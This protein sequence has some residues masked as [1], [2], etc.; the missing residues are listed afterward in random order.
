[1]CLS[2][3]RRYYLVTLNGALPVETGDVRQAFAAAAAAPHGGHVIVK[4]RTV[5]C[6]SRKEIWMGRQTLNLSLFALL[7]SAAVAL[8][9]ELIDW[10]GDVTVADA[11]TLFTSVTK[12]WV[13]WCHSS[14]FCRETA[15]CYVTQDSRFSLF[16]PNLSVFQPRCAKHGG[17][18]IVQAD[19]CL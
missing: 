17:T 16:K 19:I 18:S 11:L 15:S 2:L 12:P 13:A 9:V 10:W 7:T 6:G 5:V 1:M 3:E 8:T 4:E 14:R